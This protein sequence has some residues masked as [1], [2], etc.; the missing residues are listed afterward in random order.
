MVVGDRGDIEPPVVKLS[1]RYRTFSGSRI[2]RF[3]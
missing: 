2:V 3:I 1:I